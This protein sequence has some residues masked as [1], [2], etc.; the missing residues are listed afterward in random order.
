MY[1]FQKM[2]LYIYMLWFLGQ[3]QACV[4]H[5]KVFRRL[6]I[7]AAKS[8]HLRDPEVLVDEDNCHWLAK[9]K[10]VGKS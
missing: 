10:L 9:V 3:L 5:A 8:F 2:K 1:N 4:H 6:E 7:T